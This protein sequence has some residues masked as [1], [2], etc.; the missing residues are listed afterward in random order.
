MQEVYGRVAYQVLGQRGVGAY[1]GLMHVHTCAEATIESKGDIVFPYR[2]KGI[3]R[4]LKAAV[5]ANN[6]L[7]R[8]KRFTESKKDSPR[9]CTTGNTDDA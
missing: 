7:E 5:Q 4:R 9:K 2:A 3:F 1:N 8:L 6:E